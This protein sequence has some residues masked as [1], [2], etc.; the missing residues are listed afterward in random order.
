MQLFIRYK[1]FSLDHV[2]RFLE[3]GHK[4]GVLPHRCNVMLLTFV[5]GLFLIFV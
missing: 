1:V 2:D 4:P 3:H 5:P